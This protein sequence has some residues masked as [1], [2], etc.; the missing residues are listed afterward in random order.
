M[1]TSS[2]MDIAITS[3]KI[4]M[5]LADVIKQTKSGKK[6]PTAAAKRLKNPSAQKK[7]PTSS[8]TGNNNNKKSTRNNSGSEQKPKIQKTKQNNPK[9]DLG[10]KQSTI[11]T[12]LVSPDKIKIQ[13]TND[14]PVANQKKVKK[15]QALNKQKKVLTASQKLTKK[16]GGQP[17]AK[18]QGRVIQID[19]TKTISLNDRFTKKKF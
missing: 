6:K 19:K 16:V 11:T 15:V 2:D 10:K 1:S 14:K 9:K 18:P 4:N 7:K 12:T 8:G 17:K 13:I 5:T 3:K